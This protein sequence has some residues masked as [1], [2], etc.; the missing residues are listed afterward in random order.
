M[1]DCEYVYD[2]NEAGEKNGVC[3]AIDVCFFVAFHHSAQCLAILYMRKFFDKIEMKS[4][5]VP[6]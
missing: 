3:D 1:R 4:P 5:M 6:I 2:M